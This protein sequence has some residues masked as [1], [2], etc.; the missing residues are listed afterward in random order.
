MQLSFGVL[1]A[2]VVLCTS[3]AL[4][5]GGSGLNVLVV[6]NQNST[7]SLQLGNEYCERRGVPPQ[8]VLR[9]TGWN[10]GALSWN[11]SDFETLL[12]DPLLATLAARSLTNQV[13]YV[14]LSMDIPYRVVDGESQNSTTSAL[15]YGF[16]TNTVPPAGLPATCSLPDA[17][18]NSYAFSELPFEQAHPGTAPTNS[19]LA[20][21]LTDTSLANAGQILNRG[22]TSDGSLPT[23][24]VYL[25]KT[26][27]WARN[28]R[29]FEFDDAMF[30]A[31]VR[32]GSSL[33][34]ID[35]NDTAFTN[36]L[37]M[38]TGLSNLLLPTNA[39]VPGAMGDSLTSYG[40]DIL[41]DS[42]QTS[43]LAF[44][45]AGAVGSY[46]TVVEP[47]NYTEKFPHPLDYFY[48]NRGFSL[49]ES[50][51][52]SLQNPYQGLLVGEPL[53]APFALRG[54]ADWSSVA[55]GA[56]LSGQVVLNPTFF[57]A[58]TNLPFGQVDLFVD[59]CFA[60]TLTNLPPA[61]GNVLSV[62][63]N[64]TVVE[65]TVL[66]DDTL[67]SVAGGLADELN[68]HVD[69]TKVAASAVGD[70]I[71]LQSLDL[72]TP[73]S[74]VT[75]SVSSSPGSSSQVTTLLSVARPAFLDTSAAGFL[76][77]AATQ[78]PAV[79]DWLALD[80]VKTN[81]VPVH[82]GVTNA[83][84]G[85]TIGTLAQMAINQV[86]ASPALQ[87]SDGVMAADLYDSGTTA[88]FF[89]YARSD[90]WPAAQIQVAFTAS[91]NLLASPGGTNT[92]E[93]NLSDLQ[94]RNHLYVSSGVTNLPVN[95]TLDTTQFADGCHELIAVACE[96]TSVRTQSHV[97]RQVRFQNTALSASLNTLLGGTNTDLSAILRFSVVANTNDLSSIEFFSTGGS[98][99]F[100]T[101]QPVAFFSVAATNLGL[102]LHPFYAVVTSTSGE[103]YRTETV[104]IRLIGAEPS[105]SISIASPS[106]TLS[107]P[108]TAGRSYDLLAATTITGPYQPIA[109]LIP[110]NSIAQ[111]TDTNPP[112][113]LRF[114][115]VR[116]SN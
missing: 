96:G 18:F 114:Y 76:G 6:V 62:T 64:G 110:S 67:A 25:E 3:E 61:A 45:D 74:N 109:T 28:V 39:F 1:C 7:N 56:V 79:G 15:F 54:T 14:L 23:Q 10:G 113:L 71:E 60:R 95:F 66:P 4:W 59:G 24:T 42:G 41:E 115:R 40:G 30:E 32:G 98:L 52:Q 82:I 73:G 69:E 80:F 20:M 90:G 13:Q 68:A 111:W 9:M 2:S 75:V 88:Q 103:R 101:N 85:A 58:A 72:A 36:L 81:G 100:V 84:S 91:S 33:I 93:D 29:F 105:F 89:L 116:L 107:W 26:T 8:N 106:V 77:L 49:A 16:K 12:R 43:L 70:R 51:Y 53:S 21:M 57:S 50:Y 55:Q 83:D 65:Y 17:S 86:N 99:G 63:L 87:S 5:A 102:G 22:V 19:F 78:T 48:Q 34:R 97:S 104:W 38:L 35:A 31:R 47:C 46:G 44:L 112:A 108:A 94:P 11:R 27:D 37:G 92:L